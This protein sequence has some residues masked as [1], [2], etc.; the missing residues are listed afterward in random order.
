MTDPENEQEKDRAE[1]QGNYFNYFT[2]IE[3]H[4][5][6]ARGTSLFLLS[7]LDWALIEGWKNSGIPLEAV[8]RGVDESFTKW[9]S[10]KVK[11][12][13]VN[14]LAYC[15]QAVM[16]AAQRLSGAGS[17]KARQAAEPPFHVDELRAY[18]QQTATKLD[19]ANREAYQS[20][21]LSVH[22]LADQAEEHLKDLE[23]LERRLTSLEEKMVAIAR[24]VTPDDVLLEIRRQLD[25]ELSPYRGK[26]TVEQITTL[27]RRYL[28]TRLLEREQL[29]RL[30]LFH[31]H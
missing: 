30:S 25:S 10:R 2:E 4:F 3:E 16:E 22:A 31:M 29:P 19:G 11:S 17:T 15:T 24:S 23:D 14:S 6:R 8:L 26:M 13:H 5:Q 9:R 1:W 7:P 20:I 27:E 18:L 12:R 28:D 21:A